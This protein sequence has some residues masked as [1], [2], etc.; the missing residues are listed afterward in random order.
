MYFTLKKF[1]KKRKFKEY[2]LGGD[3][4]G[5]NTNL[6]IAGVK[7]K[8]PELLFSLHYKTK[9]L[10]NIYSTIN[11]AL[12]YS[13]SNYN[14]SIKKACL[15]VAGVV[16]DHCYAELTNIKWNINTKT[17][18]KKTNLKSISLINDFEAIGY[19]INLLSRKDLI[20][21]N[22]IKPTEKKVKAIIGAG[23]GLGKSVLY[24]DNK[25]DYYIPLPTEGGHKDFPAQNDEELKLIKYVQRLE[26][27]KKAVSYE[28]L[29]S[30]PGIERIYGFV[31][32]KLGSTKIT[33]Q[34]DKSKAKAKLI[35][36]YR[37]RD[38]VCNKT[39]QIFTKIYA[40]A[41]KNI[42]LTTLCFGG[43]YIAGGIA[44]K[45]LDIFNKKDFKE[46]FKNCFKMEN[47]LKQIPIFII[48]NYDVSLY[49]SALAAI[50]I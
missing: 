30:G 49:G 44:T 47:V 18:F 28:L 15:A 8:K 32:K 38:K 40:K 9:K 29:L 43:L 46:E 14:I 34:I 17:I 25:L 3:I 7:G 37:K 2:V 36:R 42:C 26:K 35:S 31:K 13:K 1:R 5:T 24:F 10:K 11:H 41:S 39:F 21:L 4:G 45:N 27:T 20:K 22:K 6:V 33:N 12:D 16:K 19:G 23:T 50:L 48:K